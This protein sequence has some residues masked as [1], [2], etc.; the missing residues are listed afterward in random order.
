MQARRVKAAGELIGACL[1]SVLSGDILL[2]EYERK[3]L[4]VGEEAAEK[5]AGKPAQQSL[6]VRA[7]TA[8]SNSRLEK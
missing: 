8:G 5:A 3:G 4:R 7:S 1:R 2:L 6:T